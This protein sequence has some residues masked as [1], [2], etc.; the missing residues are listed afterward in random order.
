MEQIF[1]LP[2]ML[3]VKYS[4]IIKIMNKLHDNINHLM[5]ALI[6]GVCSLGVSFIGDMSKNIQNMAASIEQLNVKMGQVNETMRDHEFRLRDL[7]KKKGD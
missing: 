4:D 7:E 3:P 1:Y 6:I 5:L 2:P